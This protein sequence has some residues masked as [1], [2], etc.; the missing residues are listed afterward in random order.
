MPRKPHLC[1]VGPGILSHFYL[2]SIFIFWGCCNKLPYTGWLKATE[3]YPLTVPEARS[4]K[5]SLQGRICSLHHPAAGGHQ[6][7]LICVHIF[8]IS[9]S[10]ITGP[11]LSVL[12][13][14]ASLIRTFVVAL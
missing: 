4:Q 9:A 7:S 10:M 8:L 13:P 12:S 11:L 6:H 2:K 5:L 1:N 14:L 3:R